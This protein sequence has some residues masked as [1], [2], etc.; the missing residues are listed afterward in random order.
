MAQELIIHDRGAVRPSDNELITDEL[1]GYLESTNPVLG[2]ENDARFGEF[3]NFVNSMAETSIVRITDANMSDGKIGDLDLTKGTEAEKKEK[4]EVVADESEYVIKD[5]KL[6]D[7]FLS[8]KD[9]S[10]LMTAMWGFHVAKDSNSGN[11]F[12]VSGYTP[13]KPS[14]FHFAKR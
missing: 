10:D 4:K 1:L 13:A 7:F 11:L 8:E 3:S 14:D 2:T 5:P 12:A 6:T 9:M